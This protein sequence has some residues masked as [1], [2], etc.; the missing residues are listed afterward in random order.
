MWEA[1]KNIQETS[2]STSCSVMGI[3]RISRRHWRGLWHHQRGERHL[4][5]WTVCCS[6]HGL[7]LHHECIAFTQL[8]MHSPKCH[9][10]AA[11]NATCADPAGGGGDGGWWEQW[12]SMRQ[13]L[14]GWALAP[15]GANCLDWGA[16]RSS[17]SHGQLNWKETFVTL[18][19]WA[20]IKRGL[21]LN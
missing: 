13:E 18:K 6:Q 14:S 3:H 5:R 20:L 10:V 8:N 12:E 4:E 15:H 2:A 1:I 17:W 9:P 7:H 16:G 21:A 11:V 19:R